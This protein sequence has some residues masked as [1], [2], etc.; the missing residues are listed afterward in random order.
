MM[1]LSTILT[2]F[3]NVSKKKKKKRIYVLKAIAVKMRSF[4]DFLFLAYVA[5]I[6]LRGR[7]FPN[8]N[9]CN[10][11]TPLPKSGLVCAK[12]NS[13]SSFYYIGESL[14]KAHKARIQS[15][16]LAQLNGGILQKSL[17]VCNVFQLAL[18]P[19]SKGPCIKHELLALKGPA[20]HSIWEIN[21]QHELEE[22][23]NVTREKY[24]A[25]YQERILSIM[26]ILEYELGEENCNRQV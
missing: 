2:F 15:C 18:Q 23:K 5:Y 10:P 20:S 12:W 8:Q 14:I 26:N 25:L 13:Y 22:V 6:R 9:I 7:S 19:T 1:A 4:Y 11:S 3:H 16:H 17:Q 24:I 21:P